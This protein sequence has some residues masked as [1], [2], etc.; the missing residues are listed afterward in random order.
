ML[1]LKKE[2]KCFETIRLSDELQS[3]FAGL[4][5]DHFPAGAHWKLPGQPPVREIN[6]NFGSGWACGVAQKEHNTGANTDNLAGD[7]PT[8]QFYCC[9]S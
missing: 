6:L 1:S 8:V 5:P 2:Q 3:Y 4:R 7:I 9:A